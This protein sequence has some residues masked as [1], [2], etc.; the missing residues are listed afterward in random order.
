[1]ISVFDFFSVSLLV[2]SITIFF[3]RFVR[4]EPPV[5]PYLV[6]ALACAIGNW[7]GEAGQEFAGLTLLVAASFLFLSVFLYPKFRPRPRDA[8]DGDLPKNA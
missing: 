5:T 6:I 3:Y 4:E 7:L 2:I 8:R 1:M